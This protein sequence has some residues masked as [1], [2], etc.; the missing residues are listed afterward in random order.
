M[1]GPLYTELTSMQ[2]EGTRARQSFNPFRAIYDLISNVWFG[3]VLMILL[4]IY[5]SVAS[6]GLLY[7]TD[8]T[9]P[10]GAWTVDVVRKRFNKTEMEVFAWWPFTLLMGLFVLNMVVVTL[11][12]IRLTVLNLGVW[13]IHTGIVILTLGS[14]YYFYNKVE[15]DTPV[16]RRSVEIKVPG[17]AAPS[18]LVVRPQN[19]VFVPGTGGEYGFTISSIN[20]NWPLLSGEDKGKT[21]CSVNVAVTTPTQSFIRQMLIGYPQ[22]TEDIIPGKGRAVKSTGK[23]LLDESLELAFAYEPQT[24][25][26]IKDTAALY[27]RKVGESQWIERPIEG[28]PHYADHTTKR[29]EVWMNRG[30]TSID[31]DPLNIAVPKVADNDPLGNLDVH[32]SGRLHYSHGDETR[33]VP[34][35]KQL[36]PM[37]KVIIDG[38]GHQSEFSLFAL[39]PRLSDVDRSMVA[40]HWA[41]N[42]MQRLG[43]GK[44]TGNQLSI[45]V[46]AQDKTVQLQVDPEKT[47]D[48]NK[49]L[50]FVRIED[51]D[52]SYRLKTYHRSFPMN[53]GRRVPIVVVEFKSGE[54]S[55]TR[56]VTDDPSR[57]QDLTGDQQF[58][59]PDPAVDVVFKPGALVTVVAGPDPENIE[60]FVGSPNDRRSVA[61][62]EMFDLGS[63]IRMKI[64]ESYS[65]MQPERRPVLVA[66]RD[67]DAKAGNIFSRIKL[68]LTSDQWEFSEWLP[69]HRYPFVND[70]Y[71]VPGRFVYRPTRCMLPDGTEVELLFSRKSAPLPAALAL[72]DFELKVHTG[73]FVSGNTLSVRDFISVLRPYSGG[74]WQQPITTSL[75]S[76]A[77]FAG[78]YFFQAEWDPGEMAFTGLGV[79]NRDGVLIQ[80]FGTCVAVLGMIYVFYIKPIIKRRRQQAV[81]AQ[82]ES[83]KKMA[84]ANDPVA[85]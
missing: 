68:E 49:D 67:R 31:P 54:R 61:I 55:I 2:N 11:R 51:T 70:Q 34:N 35:G 77:Q 42:E 6:A 84:V 64:L 75:N 78:I 1:A 45:R 80:L 3:I 26:Y 72:E 58:S 69:Y 36:N 74:E 59:P 50:Q 14:V 47:L 16:F 8:W 79:G 32:I 37:M 24:H 56:W 85:V 7:P 5:M 81:W 33:W 4:F 57:A 60:V 44:S 66:K 48:H 30:N 65:H 27:V 63:G 15:G 38:S 52:W 28:L 39:N 12:R 25:Y 29:N 62:G 20:P 76:P 17:A 22:Y 71:A 83:N 9:D 10:F 23:K 43:F 19:R 82:V 18:R 73:G 40:Y 13:M 46:P 41:E 21:A 53:N